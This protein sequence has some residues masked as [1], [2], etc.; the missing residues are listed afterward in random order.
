MTEK[1]IG[2]AV[3][4][5]GGWGAVHARVY[6]ENPQARL[7]AVA[8]LNRERAEEIASIYGCEVY[9]D[10]EKLLLRDDIQ[11]ISV[12]TPEHLHVEPVVAVA[13]A[14]KNMLLEKPIATNLQDAAAIAQAVERANIEVMVGFEYRF[15]HERV[16]MKQ[17]ASSGMLG[18]LILA[19]ARRNTRISTAR[20]VAPRLGPGSELLEEDIHDIDQVLWWAGEEVESVYAQ[21]VD[22]V[23]TKEFPGVSDL[24]WLLLRFKSGAMG[25]LESTWVLRDFGADWENPPDWKPEYWVADDMRYELVGSEGMA[26]FDGFPTSVYA[27]DREGWKFP[28]LG[29]LNYMYGEFKGSLAMELAHFVKCLAEGRKHQGATLKDGLK[30]LE[31]ALAA[32][33]SGKRGVPIKLPLP[34]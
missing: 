4:G 28:E 20:M 3:I 9:T 17:Y 19:Y 21:S 22:K 34:R 16:K 27:Y 29:T 13:Q 2:V 33:E 15:I 6:A 8:D 18:E 1:Q 23:L 30:A 31:V 25:S 7:V 26:F 10:Y 11:L 32:I 5:V 24:W 14:G 12:C